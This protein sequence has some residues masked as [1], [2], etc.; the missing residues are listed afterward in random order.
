M[1]GITAET[2]VHNH[3]ASRW[4][5]DERPSDTSHPAGNEGGQIDLIAMGAIAI[6]GKGT[7]SGQ[8]KSEP[9]AGARP[10]VPDVSGDALLLAVQQANRPITVF[11]EHR[12][13]VYTNQALVDLLG[14][15]R[16][17]LIGTDP[18]RILP[19]SDLSAEELARHRALPWGVERFHTEIT[20]MT[21]DGRR[22]Q[23]RISSAP[24]GEPSAS[25]ARWSIDLT[26]DITDEW[27][28]R[29]LERDMLDVLASGLSYEETGQYLATRVAAITPGV[30]VSVCGIRDGRMYPWAAPSFLPE[31]GTHFD[32]M[33]IGEG[34]AGC[35]TAAVRGEPVMIEDIATHPFWEGHRHV[36]L[37]SGFRSNW[38][39]PAKDRDG[40]VVATFAFYFR[41]APAAEQVEYLQRIAEAGTRLTTLAIEREENRRAVH[42]LVQFDPL[43]GLPN[44]TYMLRQLATR[45]GAGDGAE[46]SVLVVNID[47]FRDVN[48]A[49]GH[50]AG[51]QVLLTV[52]GR[53]HD[54]IG[55]HDL[56]A[57]TQGD[58]F[59][60]LTGGDALVLA[61]R[62]LAALQ[63][64]M[65][66][67]GQQISLVASIGIS[68]ATGDREDTEA[69]L[70][71][72]EAAVQQVK[73]QGG[74]S[75]AVGGGAETNPVARDRLLMSSALKRA[76]ANDQ[77]ALVYQPQVETGSGRLHGLEALV[78]WCDPNFGSVPPGKFVALAEETGQI[79]ALSRWVLREACRQ[80]ASWRAD[81]LGVPSV[82]VNLSPMNF[83]QADLPA[84]I[85]GLL[86]EYALPGECLVAEMTENTVV[87]LTP[88]MLEV[89]EGIRRLGVGLSVDDLGTGYSSLTNLVSL[90][91]TEVKIDR[92]FIAGMQDQPGLR[93][94]VAAVVGLG[95]SLGLAVVA[96]GVET[97]EQRDLLSSLRGPIIQGYLLSPPLPPDRAAEWIVR[98]TATHRDRPWTTSALA[99]RVT[100]PT[101][102][103][104]AAE[105]LAIIIT[106]AT[107]AV[108]YATPTYAALYAEIAGDAAGEGDLTPLALTACAIEPQLSEE[109]AQHLQDGLRWEREGN[110]TFADGSLRLLR[111]ATWP[112]RAHD[113]ED[114]G[115]R[116]TLI[117]DLLAID[118][119][120]QQLNRM[121]ARHRMI[122]DTA[123][124]AI[125]IA[126]N[127]IIVYANLLA[128]RLF[129]D[130]Y[131]DEL[132][133]RPVDEV[134]PPSERAGLLARLE[135]SR[136]IPRRPVLAELTIPASVSYQ[137]DGDRVV[138]RTF[139]LTTQLNEDGWIAHIGFN[140]ITAQ[141]HFQRR[142]EREREYSDTVIDALPGIFYHYD[143][144][145]HMRRWNRNHAVLT[146]HTP[147]DLLDSTA[148]MH[149]SE[150]E[151]KKVYAAMEDVF[152]TGYATVEANFLLAD[153]TEEP[154]LLTGIRF[155][156][157]DG[158]VGLIGIGLSIKEQRRATE[159]ARKSLSLLKG[160]MSASAEGLL[161][162][163]H[164]NLELI[165]NPRFFELWDMSPEIIAATGP[166]YID[167]LSRFLIA[168]VVEVDH[169]VAV[170]RRVNAEP[171]FMAD[172]EVSLLNGRTL[173]YHTAPLVDAAGTE[174]ERRYGRTWVFRDVTEERR[175]Q[176]E[177][178][179]LANYDAVT[180]LPNRHRI[181]QIIDEVSRDP[182]ARFGVMV[183]DLDNF[184]DINDGYG[185]DVGDHALTYTGQRLA[186]LLASATPDAVIA[187]YGGDEFLVVVRNISDAEHMQ[188][189]LDAVVTGLPDPVE[190]AGRNMRISASAGGA[191]FPQDADT[192]EGLLKA[193]DIAMYHAK[194]AGRNRAQVFNA[195]FAEQ[196]RRAVSLER[197]LR[198]AI[199]NGQLEMHY[200][201][202][203]DTITGNITGFEALMRWHHP[204]E[205]L[206]PP[207]T[208]IALAE[209]STLINQ[210]GSWALGEVCAQA[211]IWL[212][213]G[214]AAPP[215]SINVS[216]HQILYRDL[217][218]EVR[219]VLAATG[220]PA[221]LLQIELTETA[222][223]RDPD[224]VSETLTRLAELGV[225]I[226]I[227]DFGTGYSS[228]SYLRAF[229]AHTLKIDK[230]FVDD[231]LTDEGDEK[232]VRATISL[233]HNLGYRVVAEGV[234]TEEQR[235]RLR[236][237]G[238]DEIQGWHLGHP[239]TVAE[240]AAFIRDHTARVAL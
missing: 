210:L 148:D 110:F 84:Y 175:A 152:A 28:I 48:E 213:A 233:A 230:S 96:E 51:D 56:L 153:G 30:S 154:Y 204:V 207:D 174:R 93:A 32:Q 53:L 42:R 168:H 61:G 208:F 83:R 205:G 191:I 239:V 200:Q 149:F 219:D 186:E 47:R 5:A 103:L 40:N 144:N 197:D 9:S 4:R 94:L 128:G 37:P 166:G 182:E 143:A 104:P 156:E 146:G 95:R 194:R 195:E 124:D 81:G 140:D 89:V 105:R 87:A 73:A 70:A 189:V 229:P 172:G 135:E 55:D 2:Q 151:A 170:L 167:D 67:D 142:L 169:V 3:V 118:G 159:D 101:G 132:L 102:L 52:A 19:A 115:L 97:D 190:L 76:I 109:F 214:V 216:A 202:K 224:L 127:G 113:E 49:L 119:Y 116:V 36:V 18:T 125:L 193:A 58:Q 57:R 25:G 39:Y 121:N 188:A 6:S 133:G 44:R 157:A 137:T 63:D 20:L 75:Y 232:I 100:S 33:P 112:M 185:H 177:A 69:L 236:E 31:Y 111:V 24:F 179:H 62:L 12:R 183:V 23:A 240:V 134:L 90:P 136:R 71:S 26:Q 34:V 99:A 79:E 21:K 217:V 155:V 199:A 64:P 150:T 85:A 228:L 91:V 192:V 78:R 173:H 74:G 107:G 13:I 220:L 106:D 226:A 17:E 77:L 98:A 227:D 161:L 201:P 138:L 234:E 60:V 22:I 165:A 218:A 131:A 14:Y 176:R 158:T 54:A 72:A 41:E 82:S 225:T 162:A 139:V 123:P 114:S 8:G 27:Q 88:D 11:D 238:C 222:L 120:V 59:V 178:E 10:D 181:R 35:G 203:A 45:L 147:E 223:A 68:V 196:R 1:H 50:A 108:Q 206:V 65:E 180:G 198:D 221:H 38:T 231:L 160:Q 187:R 164:D 7:M 29:E 66:I 235:E 209:E 212:D 43:T 145:G 237:L 16:E 126:E 117:V 184:K 15:A 80:L 215:V 141:H 92:T 171:D 163:D 129:A 130:G 211:K 46:A 86:E 122:V